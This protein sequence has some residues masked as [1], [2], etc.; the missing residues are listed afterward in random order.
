MGLRELS[1][2]HHRLRAEG[3]VR[4]VPG[5]D[6]KPVWIVTGYDEVIRLL[7]DSR[8]V[9][10]KPG[11]PPGDPG[12]GLPEVL[13][14][15]L[16]NMDAA[17]HRRIRTLAAP[18][19]GRY[20]GEP[21]RR[22][23]GGHVTD[24]LGE[25]EAA[26]QPEVDVFARL[27]APLQARVMADV[28]GVLAEDADKFATAALAVTAFDPGDPRTRQGMVPA[29]H[30]VV[31]CLQRVIAAR[32]A[33]PADDVISGWLAAGG[34]TGDEILSLAFLVF[35]ASQNSVSQNAN[36]IG[37]LA[38]QDRDELLAEVADEGRWQK[39]VPGVLSE[40]LVGSYAVRRFNLDDMTFGDVTIP[41]E[42]PIFLSLRAAITDPSSDPKPMLAFG[43]GI[44]YCLAA[45]LALAEL[46]IMTREVFRRFP[47]IA[48]VYKFD[49]VKM[50]GTWRTHGP[51][52][53]RMIL[54]AG[55][56]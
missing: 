51:V 17:E 49:T 12:F 23:V 36:A 42:S 55:K 44:H 25:I 53:L 24:L 1:D 3:P 33:E 50:R 45:E 2:L 9:N 18:A 37:V 32:Q 13:A 34:L 54:D 30:T 41:A 35:L 31:E 10:K 56:A 7:T 43:R 39:R 21:V 38:E 52:Q 6:G 46:D 22:L 14:D 26:G 15:N 27:A 28:L 20:R 40:S 16:L 5:P 11:T 8:V 29:T 48:P 19:F 4:E 47:R